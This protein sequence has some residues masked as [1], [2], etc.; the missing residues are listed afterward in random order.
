MLRPLCVHPK[1]A[2]TCT[3]NGCG[4]PE[5][6]HVHTH[7][8]GRTCAHRYSH[9]T[10][11]QHECIPQANAPALFLVLQMVR[12]SPPQPETGNG[13]H[14]RP[15]LCLPL[16]V[17]SC[18]ELRSFAPVPALAQTLSL[19]CLLLA[20][21]PSLLSTLTQAFPK[22]PPLLPAWNSCS[23]TWKA[24]L[25]AERGPPQI[26]VSRTNGHSQ[27]PRPSFFQFFLS[28]GGKMWRHVLSTPLALSDVHSKTVLGVS[29]VSRRYFCL[30][31]SLGL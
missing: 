16:A 15:S 26:L 9:H 21:C 27:I 6:T 20:D 2:F 8:Q 3:F 10:P 30:L 7:T 31:D 18:Q 5:Y 4:E 12:L 1:S 28:Q 25:A 17:V 11:T 22:F 29:W 19:S 14:R 23:Q 13:A 24:T